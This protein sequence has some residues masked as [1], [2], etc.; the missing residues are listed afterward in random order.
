M[1]YSV[2]KISMQNNLSSSGEQLHSNE[3]NENLT[4]AFNLLKHI[5]RRTNRIKYSTLI[6]FKIQTSIKLIQIN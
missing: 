5:S 6:N 4:R 2:I 3:F 1:K